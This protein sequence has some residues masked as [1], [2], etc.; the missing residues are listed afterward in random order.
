M[1]HLFLDSSY[2]IAL[3]DEGD[4]HHLEARSHL[5]SLRK[6]LPQYVTTSF[7]FDEVVTFFNSKRFH[8]KAIE[9]GSNL[10]ASPSVEFI[11]IDENI[12]YEAWKYLKI[13]RD[14][15]YS[16]TDCISFIVMKKFEITTALTFDKHF[17]Q[18]G[19]NI[20]PVS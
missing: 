6:S 13:H 2:I 20:I 16:M 12:F 4:Y 8:Q 11:F 5:Q 3:E 9:I 18:A 10:L 1:T 17:S 15:T 7:V 14:K 19:F